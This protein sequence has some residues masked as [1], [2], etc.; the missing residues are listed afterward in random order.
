MDVKEIGKKLV[1]YCNRGENKKAI[2]ELYGKDIVS[3]EA[4]ESPEM[5]A[6]M[7]GIDQIRGKNDWW[8]ENH[9]VHSGVASGPY[10]N[11][12]KFAVNFKYD[13]TPK[14]GP[15]AGK[16]VKMDEVA[17]YTVKDGKIVREEFYY[18]M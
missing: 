11:K 9:E 15:M 5:P 3:V 16:R 2:D 13:I 1:E 17:L 10:P 6:E 8:F 18:D 4:M 12:D 14:A 7:R